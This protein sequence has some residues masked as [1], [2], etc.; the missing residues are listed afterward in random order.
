M[1][2]CIEGSRLTQTQWVLHAPGSNAGQVAFSGK[3]SH[4]NPYTQTHYSHIAS[5]HGEF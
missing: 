4:R 5:H 1:Y 3:T 2:A